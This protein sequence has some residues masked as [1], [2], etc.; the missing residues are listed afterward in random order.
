[1]RIGL[2]FFGPKD[3][4]NTQLSYPSREKRVKMEVSVL[5]L[6]AWFKPRVS[7]HL[8]PSSISTYRIKLR[9]SL[10][11]IRSLT[12]EVSTPRL[13]ADVVTPSARLLLRRSTTEKRVYTSNMDLTRSY[14]LERR[15]SGP[16]RMV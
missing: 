1:M 13:S 14:Y 15:L 3:R 12:T 10:H 7:E 2:S 16:L 9:A 5:T 8:P 11:T 6:L 4:S